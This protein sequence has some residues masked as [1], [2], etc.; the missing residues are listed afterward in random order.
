[1]TAHSWGVSVIGPE[2]RSEATRRGTPSVDG[3]FRERIFHS[4]LRR[5]ASI[6]RFV[7]ERVIVCLPASTPGENWKLPLVQSAR[8]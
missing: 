6:R 1:M 7:F 2:C 5:A 3:I 4:S 8:E